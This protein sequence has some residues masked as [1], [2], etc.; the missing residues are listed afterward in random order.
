MSGDGLLKSRNDE[1]FRTGL[2]IIMIFG[3]FLL[4]SA[5]NSIGSGTI[6]DIFAQERLDNKSVSRTPITNL[7]NTIGDSLYPQ[8]AV[9]GR[10]MYLVW[11]D[12]S[13]TGN[14]RNYEI[15][16][17]RSTDGGASFD[18][19]IINLSNNTG[20]SDDVQLA[21]TGSNIYVV[22]TDDTTGNREIL[23]TKSIDGGDTFSEPVNLSNNSGDSYNS[24]IA[25][26]GNNVYVVWNDYNSPEGKGGGMLLG[27][28]IDG[29]DTFS[30]PN[31]LSNNTKDSY[32]KIATDGNSSNVFIVWNNE[33]VNDKVGGVF[34]T[35]SSDNATTFSEVAKLNGDKSFGEP[36]ITAMYNSSRD[37]SDVYIVW[38]SYDPPK[39]RSDIFFTKST[40]HGTGFSY[41]TTLTQ[42]ASGIS[43]DVGILVSG[44]KI[45]IAWEGNSSGNY[46][47]V[48][49]KSLDYGNTFSN[50]E[51]LSNNSE[52]S[53]CPQMT[54][55][56]DGILYLV[57]EDGA[58]GKKEILLSTRTEL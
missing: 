7:S 52:E 13:F 22:W 39:N 6:I 23:F 16:L 55:S 5:T 56:N 50:A 1:N 36:Q 27:K 35:N 19:D 42:D 54:L 30:Q 49:I 29:G 34:F 46:E 37:S 12:N 28:S 44:G 32:P 40:D 25:A 11:Q 43:R 3:I 10:N 31:N 21:I 53:L 51:N 33:T 18:K 2:N 47:I 45:Y 20:L 15:Y 9:Y 8:L 58:S 48:L 17:K 26:A 4:I 57:W 24:E 14:E 41:P 38:D